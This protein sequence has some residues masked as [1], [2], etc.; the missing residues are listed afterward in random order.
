MTT[1]A[2]GLTPSMTP[3]KMRLPTGPEDFK[4]LCVIG[5]GAFGKVVQVIH[6]PTQEVLAMKVSLH[7]HIDQSSSLY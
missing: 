6:E 3:S 4:L 5:K 7:L 1:E 2:T